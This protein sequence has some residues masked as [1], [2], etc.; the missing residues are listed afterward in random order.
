[1]CICKCIYTCIPKYNLFSLYHVTCMYVFRVDHLEWVAIN[2]IGGYGLT[3][4]QGG[5][6]SM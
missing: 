6:G 5:G 3:R 2:E 4:Q 1:M